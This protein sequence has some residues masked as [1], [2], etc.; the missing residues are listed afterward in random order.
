MI[1]VLA[2]EVHELKGRPNNS[3]TFGRSDQAYLDEL[4]KKA[5]KVEV[6]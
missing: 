4:R 2:K 3:W 6:K 5:A 1:A